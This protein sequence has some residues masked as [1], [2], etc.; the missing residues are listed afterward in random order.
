MPGQKNHIGT[1]GGGLIFDNLPSDAINPLVNNHVNYYFAVDMI[2]DCK[3]TVNTTIKC[4]RLF[5]K[6]RQS[7]LFMEILV[8]QLTPTIMCLNLIDVGDQE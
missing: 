8:E 5:K 4:K 3:I 1:G 2:V 6:M 7:N